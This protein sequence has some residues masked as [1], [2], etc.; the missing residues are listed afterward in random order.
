MS[1]RAYNPPKRRLSTV[2]AVV[3][4]LVF[5]LLVFLAI[6]LSQKIAN[7]VEGDTGPTVTLPPPP[8]A[9]PASPNVEETPPD[10]PEPE[11]F[12]EP[13][14]AADLGLEPIEGI[15]LTPGFGGIQ[16]DM[17]GMLDNMMPGDALADGSL[18]R[19]AEPTS[20][21]RPVIP[22]ALKASYVNGTVTVL[23]KID[24][25]GRI[26]DVRVKSSTEPR[27]DA[28]AIAA[29]RKWKFKPAIKG[30]KKTKDTLSIP[31]QLGTT[32]KN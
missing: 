11:E 32:R 2:F 4:G 1:R 13:E 17:A 28:Y 18:D 23:V 12:V 27:L 6:P 24:E 15:A 10:I 21:A 3:A 8:A 20:Q 19:R 25:E 31:I 14:P 29:V 5:T 26:I 30:G 9:P 7:L 22:R 16:I